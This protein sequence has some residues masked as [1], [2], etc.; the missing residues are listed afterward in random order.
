V[1]GLA[2]RD[3][4]ESVGPRRLSGVVARPLTFTVRPQ[5]RYVRINFGPSHRDRHSSKLWL[6]HIGLPRIALY[7]IKKFSLRTPSSLALHFKRRAA[8]S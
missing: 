4:G 5:P 7:V 1:S 8:A 6:K 2:L 3:P